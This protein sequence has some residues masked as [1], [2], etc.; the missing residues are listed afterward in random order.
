MTEKSGFNIPWASLAVLVAFVSSVL[1][2]PRA[3]DPLRPPE[4]DSA[5]TSTPTVLEV[6]SRLWEDPFGAMRR[7]ESERLSRCDKLKPAQW[8]RVADCDD[9][10]VLARRAPASLWRGLD[11]NDDKDR[12][13]TLVV[14]ALVP[15]NQFVGAEETRRRTRYALLAGFHAKGYV[16][17]N[18]GRIGILRFDLARQACGNC[19]ASFVDV[20]YELLSQRPILRGD[21]ARSARRYDQIALLWID[22]TALPAPKLDHLAR[23]LGLLFDGSERAKAPQLAVIG[24]SS[25]DAM[26]VA[27]T[28]LERATRN[29]ELSPQERAGYLQLARAEI[30]S[31][32]STAPNAHFEM[33]KGQ[34]LQ[35]FVTE[36]LQ[37][38]TTPKD[39][40][41]GLFR[42]TIASDS[43]VL[44]SLV[45]ELNLR[46]PEGAKRRVVLVAERDSLYAQGLVTELTHRMREATLLKFEAQ[47]FF[48]G[49][50]GVTPR[51]SAEKA[52]S[53]K[54][55]RPEAAI[56]WPESRD[57]LDYLRRM[58]ASLKASEAAADAGPIGAIGIIGY[59]VHDKLLV[60]QALHETFSDKV[61]F[62][63]DMDA[64]YLHPRTLAFTRNLV[65]A[66][67]LPLEFAPDLQAGVA[68]LRD[69]YQS[70]TYLAARRAACRGA[71]CKASEDALADEAL[72][73]PSV[74]E[75]GRTR[76]VAVAGYGHGLQ[77]GSSNVS[78]STVAATLVI[79]LAVALLVW[80]STPALLRARIAVLGGTDGHSSAAPAPGG[81]AAVTRQAQRAVELPIAMLVALHM[82]LLAYAVGSAIEF[83]RAGSLGV[84]GVVSLTTLVGIAALFACYPRPNG[85]EPPRRRW[86][87][88]I[89][90]TLVAGVLVWMAWSAERQIPCTECEPVAWL[91]GVSAWP[92]HLIRLLALFGIAVTFDLLW[93]HALASMVEDSI[94]LALPVRPKGALR[95]DSWRRGAWSWFLRNTLAGWR[96]PECRSVEF[97]GLWRQYTRRGRTA[98]RVVRV[99]AWYV[100]TLAVIAV[101]FV[102]FS[103]G[104]VPEIPVRG[105]DQRRL[106]AWTLYAALLLLPLLTVAVADATLLAC[107]FIRHLKRARTHYPGD[108][109]LR[110][111]QALGPAHQE[112]WIA[113]IAADPSNRSLPGPLE[114]CDQ[115]SLLDDWIDVQVV[116]RR[117]R[118]VAPLV[119]G[120][121]CVLALLVVAHSRLFDNWA[122]TLPIVLGA[123]GYLV[124]LIALSALLKLTAEQT[125]S[126]ALER[127]NADLRWLGG[128]QDGK[129]VAPYERLIKSVEN[130]QAG[131]F[132]PF[133]EQPFVRA[134]LVPLGG[135]GGVQ[136]FDQLLLGR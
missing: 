105:A 50:D 66:S 77:R 13:D 84:G 72:D 28:D 16:P 79:L 36:R 69:V 70:A 111:A 39:L 73:M 35:D 7:H 23:T 18:A 17:D 101:L 1:L 85:Q 8:P 29:T 20:A 10:T 109:V 14:T 132:A 90:L 62:T 4:K 42:R 97:V 91:E 106:V 34:K 67:S 52:P 102:A 32:S 74:Y 63:T 123:G 19:P 57:Q 59:D 131:A 61:F 113:P 100:V 86:F 128:V 45:K 60:L 110:F 96:R 83:V 24:P 98:A 56:E 65:V 71:P 46:L 68:P 58:A 119:I 22:E 30:L 112:V 40:P 94:W 53:D 82:A 116:A 43:L 121:F 126:V 95:T 33:L 120:P 107:R 136:L 99:L 81:G 92:S 129:L 127:M 44:R 80:P 108:T 125:R 76:A 117:T 104:Y 25:S 115:H 9:A 41:A 47:Y 75:I 134:L 130:N 54:S 88:W 38:F 133:F 49:I 87:A 2:P 21:S 12:S 11:R 48:R 78:R 103:D 26:R 55:A 93:R 64:R 89:A 37:T 6:E 27:L 15:G 3:F 31:P 51:A 5:Q 114:V 124:W 118:E 122:V 135:A